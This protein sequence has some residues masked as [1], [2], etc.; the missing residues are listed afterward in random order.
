MFSIR[1]RL[2][3]SIK[4]RRGRS[5]NGEGAS[6][7]GASGD[8]ASGESATEDLPEEAKKAAEKR[9]EGADGKRISFPLRQ[10]SVI[11]SAFRQNLP[12]AFLEQLV[13]SVTT[14][15]ASIDASPERT[16]QDVADN[17]LAFIDGKEGQANR[18]L[19]NARHLKYKQMGIVKTMH[20]DLKLLYETVIEREKRQG[21]T[22]GLE[23][24][25]VGF[26]KWYID[27][28]KDA[29]RRAGVSLGEH[30]EV[31]SMATPTTD[32]SRPSAS[33]APTC[34]DKQSI[35]K[36]GALSEGVVTTRVLQ[37]RLMNMITQPENSTV[38]ESRDSLA[39]NHDEARGVSWFSDRPR[40]ATMAQFTSVSSTATSP[41]NLYDEHN[42]I[43][44]YPVCQKSGK[45]PG[46][47]ATSKPTLHKGEGSGKLN[48]LQDSLSTRLT[49][50]QPTDTNFYDHQLQLSPYFKN[51]NSKALKVLGSR[52]EPVGCHSIPPDNSKRENRSFFLT[53]FD[54]DAS[55]TRHS[56]DRDNE[57]DCSFNTIAIG[58]T[59]QSRNSFDSS[60]ELLAP[61]D[62]GLDDS[63]ET[64]SLAMKC[65]ATTPR[66]NSRGLS[67]GSSRAN[68]SMSRAESEALIVRL[69][70]MGLHFPG[71]Q[72]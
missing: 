62:Q 68:A 67:G 55:D 4:S 21:D 24:P 54:D 5:T 53:G 41:S 60:S 27:F 39:T 19:T 9:D 33:N 70:G 43:Q 3:K 29:H 57:D 6:E 20:I 8:Q 11:L 42:V 59:G 2:W 12:K 13:P 30:D 56:Y 65:F 7:D 71:R 38:P 1:D 52:L 72:L 47:P 66:T 64:D 49:S 50:E 23:I 58:G 46:Q 25:L 37:E 16:I 26:K 69:E 40:S 17:L 61:T 36:R 28:Y 31:L 44:G 22:V 14:L 34:S 32:I 15:R 51:A 35:D 18:V 10:L 63:S 45:L 48:L